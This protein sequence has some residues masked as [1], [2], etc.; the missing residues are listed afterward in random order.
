MGEQADLI[1]N[2]DVC[3]FCGENFEDE[4]FGYPRTCRSCAV[5]NVSKSRNPLKKEKI[6]EAQRLFKSAGFEWETF[7]NGYHWKFAG[8]DFYPSTH[9]WMDIKNDFRGE[10]IKEFIK[11]VQTKK[12]KETSVR[13]LT[14]EQI[15]DIAK[16]INGSLY[17]R[18]EA[19]HR[20]IYL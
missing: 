5:Q 19:I 3:Q 9:R 17:E 14:V 13:I 4:G 2:G 11:Y 15:F 1:L 12:H 6:A 20:G 16:R 10:G 8:L 7:N 18:C